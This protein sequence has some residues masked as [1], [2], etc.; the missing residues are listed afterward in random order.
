MTLGTMN[1]G[2]WKGRESPAVAE[3]NTLLAEAGLH[4]QAY[5]LDQNIIFEHHQTHKKL[6]IRNS[7]TVYMHFNLLTLCTSRFSHS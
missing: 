7:H 4:P 5:L 6:N 1:C 3:D 2:R